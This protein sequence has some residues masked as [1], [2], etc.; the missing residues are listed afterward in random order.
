MNILYFL[1]YATLRPV[2]VI[3]PLAFPTSHKSASMNMRVLSLVASGFFLVARVI[4]ST[5]DR[6]EIFESLATAP[7]GWILESEPAASDE[8]YMRVHLKQQNVQEFEEKLINVSHPKLQ[9]LD[10]D[11]KR[12]PH[13]AIP[14]MGS[15]CHQLLSK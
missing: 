15:I 1:Y 2:L 6:Y 12:Y 4:A 13:P 9:L 5:N 14:S 8:L 10:I 3:R 11:V 7:K